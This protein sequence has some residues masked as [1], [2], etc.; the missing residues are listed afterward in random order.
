[1]CKTVSQ[2][3]ALPPPNFHRHK[4]QQVL[5]VLPGLCCVLGLGLVVGGFLSVDHFNEL[6]IFS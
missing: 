5:P 1:M 6:E 4:R 3:M 2:E